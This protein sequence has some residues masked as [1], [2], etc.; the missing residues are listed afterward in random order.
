MLLRRLVILLLIDCTNYNH[1]VHVGGHCQH[2]LDQMESRWEAKE[3]VGRQVLLEQEIIKNHHY[4]ND[5]FES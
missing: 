1:A 3:L 4:G 5:D 2:H